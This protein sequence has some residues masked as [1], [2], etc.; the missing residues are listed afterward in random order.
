[1]SI[2]NIEL[3]VDGDAGFDAAN[4]FR[5]SQARYF[6]P[7]VHEWYKAA[8]YDPATGGYWDY[9]TGSDSDTPPAA[10]AGGTDPN[11]A[12][13][14]QDYEQGPADITQAGGLSPYGVMGLGGNVFEWEE[15]TADLMNDDG[16]RLSFRGMRSGD[17]PNTLA[18]LWPSHRTSGPPTDGNSV[19]GFRVAS[20]VPEPSGVVLAL[21]ALTVLLISSRKNKAV[22][23]WTE[24]QTVR[25]VGQA[26]ATLPGPA[27]HGAGIPSCRQITRTSGSGI[28]R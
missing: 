6:L 2:A 26:L 19:V 11:T 5:N 13:Y 4:R 14:E 16:S 27:C 1:M 3:W 24:F 9:P 22:Y 28:S 20:A 17:W 7:S 15:T 18:S 23:L 12:V 21:L 10:V 25:S 8:Y